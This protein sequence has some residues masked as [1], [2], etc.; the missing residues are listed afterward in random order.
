MRCSR[1]IIRPASSTSCWRRIRSAWKFRLENVSG[2]FLIMFTGIVEEA[3]AVE[4][5]L[6]TPKSIQ[7]AIRAEVCAQ[8][9][10]PGASLAV[11]GC[12]LT[13]VNIRTVS[14]R[15]KLLHFDLLRE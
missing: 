13:V 14:R 12:C 6:R 8:G 10:K 15:Q 11:N 4:K 3:G 9:L 1:I 2:G 7:L 5:I